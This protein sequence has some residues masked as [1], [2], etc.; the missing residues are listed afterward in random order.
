MV[1][2]VWAGP[3]RAQQKAAPEAEAPESALEISWQ[4][5]EDCDRGEAVRAK[6]T[7]LLGG[8]QRAASSGVKV[9][10]SV[11]RQ[12][13]RYVA[14][15]ETTSSAGGGKKRLEGESCEAIALASAVVIALSVDPNASLDAETTVEEPPPEPRPVPKAKPRAR[16]KP[17]APRKDPSPRDT[18]AYLHGSVGA[19]FH[20]FDGPLAFT[21]AGVGIRYRRVSVELG[22]AVYQARDV[23]LPEHPK[24]GAALRVASG[25][26]LA[27]YAALPFQLGAVEV[28][29]GA[30]LEYLSAAAFGVSHPDAAQ[31][32]V[33]A[34]VAALRG[35]LRATSWLSAALDV[36]ATARPWQPHFVL[37]GVGDVFGTP[38]VSP[39]ARTGLMLEF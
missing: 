18:R 2:A 38:V 15:L 33:L 27:C 26:L 23:T 8:S 1:A 30:R 25:E 13:G 16:P 22:G 29:P 7:R 21:G 24:L 31:V 34:G 36:G 11:E 4:G 9:S 20:L 3:A 12:R 10:V 32:L 5:P 28:C 19:L 39:F 35:R 37:V 14:V 17:V 6:V